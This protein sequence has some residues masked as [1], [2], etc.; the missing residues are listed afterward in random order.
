MTSQIRLLACEEASPS[1]LLVG[2]PT[3]PPITACHLFSALYSSSNT[4]LAKPAFCTDPP[5]PQ[6]NSEQNSGKTP[7]RLR[8][9]ILSRRETNTLASPSPL[10]S[11]FAFL[12]LGSRKI[13]ANENRK[14]EKKR[15]KTETRWR[16][17]QDQPNE[18]LSDLLRLQCLRDTRR[19]S[20][21][22]PLP[23]TNFQILEKHTP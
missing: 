3:T 14:K 21:Q 16:C 6:S 5:Q 7:L 11:F 18:V 17:L 9:L 2:T 4:G 13:Y 20:H 12:F 10:L 8:T 1:S 23:H 19:T 15:T 22:L